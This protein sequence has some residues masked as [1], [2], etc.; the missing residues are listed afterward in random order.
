MI[1]V[2]PKLRTWDELRRPRSRAAL[3]L[4]RSVH[5]QSLV[6]LRM[7]DSQGAFKQTA[8]KFNPRIVSGSVSHLGLQVSSRLQDCHSSAH[9][10]T[11]N[12]SFQSHWMV[13]LLGWCCLPLLVVHFYRLYQIIQKKGNWNS[14]Q[15]RVSSSAKRMRTYGSLVA[16][17]NKWKSLP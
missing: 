14:L 12:F 10:D 17:L 11:F 15:V 8:A 6:E 1:H 4:A 13:L 9:W 5:S 16:L 2:V 7:H 3:R